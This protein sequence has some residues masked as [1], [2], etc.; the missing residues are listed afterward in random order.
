MNLNMSK[1]VEGLRQALT[2]IRSG[3]ISPSLIDQTKVNVYGQNMPLKAVAHTSRKPTGIEIT[4]HDQEITGQIA[5]SLKAA[6]FNAYVFSKQS[7]MVA[8]EPPSGDQ[9]KQV[10]LKVKQ[11]G[12]EAKIAVRNIR[13]MHKK[14]I[15]ED[16]HTEDEERRLL[17]VLQTETDE[18]VKM[19]DRIIKDKVEQ[20]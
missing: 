2:G 8:T 20:L 1:T 15:E 17:K 16:D 12:E 14:G 9:K 7:V 5:N 10:A 11:L 18:A 4:P 6:G 19:I 3:T 13:T